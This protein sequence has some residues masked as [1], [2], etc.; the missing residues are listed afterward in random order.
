MNSCSIC[1][2]NIVHP[3]DS[4][5]LYNYVI[6]IIDGFIAEVLPIKQ[7]NGKNDKT[8]D[9]EGCWVMPGIIDMHTHITFEPHYTIQDEAY[10]KSNDFLQCSINNLNEMKSSG[11]TTCRDMGSHNNSTFIVKKYLLENNLYNLPEIISCGDIIT[12]ESGHMCCCGHEFKNV[13]SL[14]S[15]LLINKTCDAKFI[16]IASDP[17]DT[18]TEGRIPNPAFT[19]EQLSQIVNI[20]QRFGFYAACHTYP[21]VEGLTRAIA[22]NVRT[23]EHAVPL[24]E[25]IKKMCDDNLFFVP[26]FVAAYDEVGILELLK[27]GISKNQILLEKIKDYCI[28]KIYNLSSVPKSL[29]EWFNIL[30]DVLPENLYKGV[31]FCIG[32]DAGCKGTDFRSALRE[33]MLLKVIGATNQQVLFAATENAAK[34]LSRFDIGIIKPGARA[35][36][37]LL[38]DNPLEIIDTLFENVG[39][40]CNG[41]LELH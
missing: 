7:Y 15:T 29:L 21:S 10:C 23:I 1:G 16:K 33:I 17:K 20:A 40:I 14:I 12:Y 5:I 38:R 32:S 28:P 31:N 41:I 39:V 4:I 18:E 27:K 37:L 11:I 35:N 19:I 13:D 2:V 22:A 34:A 24:N 3:K 36:L 30:C 9:F 25:D 6:R 26:T 8:H